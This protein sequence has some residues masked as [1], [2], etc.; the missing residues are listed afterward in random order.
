MGLRDLQ[1]RLN[2]KEVM[3]MLVESGKEQRRRVREPGYDRTLLHV[4]C[5]INPSGK[6]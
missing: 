1:G 2:M 5:G 4:K 6:V 3:Y